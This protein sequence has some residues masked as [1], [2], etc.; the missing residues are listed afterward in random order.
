[1]KSR[2]RLVFWKQKFEP[3]VIVICVRRYMQFCEFPRF[4]RH[5]RCTAAPWAIVTR[6]ASAAALPFPAASGRRQ[7]A[8]HDIGAF[9]ITARTD[10]VEG[11][12]DIGK[13]KPHAKT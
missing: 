7:G 5:S 12:T 3:R 6:T 10:K 13:E 9:P 8:I 1:M 11:Q 2:R 4:G